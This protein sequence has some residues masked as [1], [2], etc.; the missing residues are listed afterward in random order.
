[1]FGKQ[2]A[3]QFIV[4]LVTRV[5]NIVVLHNHTSLPRRGQVG[6]WFDGKAAFFIG[7]IK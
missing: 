6:D 2:L 7:N 3:F 5:E 4:D 1:M